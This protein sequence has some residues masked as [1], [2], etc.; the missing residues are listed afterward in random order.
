MELGIPAMDTYMICTP[1][2]RCLGLLR[3]APDDNNE[4]EGEY[5]MSVE[6]LRIAA[7]ANCPICMRLLHHIDN[8]LPLVLVK[9]TPGPDPICIVWKRDFMFDVLK[10]GVGVIQNNEEYVSTT[11]LMLYEY[12]PDGT[13]LE[14]N[15]ERTYSAFIGVSRYH[16][17]DGSLPDTTQVRKQTQQWVHAAKTVVLWEWGYFTWSKLRECKIKVKAKLMRP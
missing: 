13:Y 5:K 11:K 6:K 12:S 17:L 15:Y 2:E 4:A 10:F 7:A 14:G 1:C 16:A 8:W 9:D 3:Q